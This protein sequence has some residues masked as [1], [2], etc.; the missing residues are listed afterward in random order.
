LTRRSEEIST[1]AADAATHFP[2]NLL[3][4]VLQ[5]LPAQDAHL[6]A[7]LLN[8]TNPRWRIHYDAA[9]WHVSRRRIVVLRNR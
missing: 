6:L 1:D 8:E 2:I 7:Q 9:G 4:R 3:E 5:L